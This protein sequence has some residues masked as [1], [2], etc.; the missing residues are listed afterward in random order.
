[1][2]PQCLRIPMEL[3]STNRRRLCERLR[4]RDDVPSAGAV[5]LLQ[6]GEQKQQ[7]CTDTD[8]VFRQ[9]HAHAHVAQIVDVIH[10]H[11]HVEKLSN[12]YSRRSFRKINIKHHP[13][14]LLQ[15]C[16][17]VFNWM[18]LHVDS[19]LH[20][21]TCTCVY[22]KRVQ[23]ALFF[24]FLWAGVL[25]PLAV[26]CDWG[27]LFCHG[28]HGHRACHSLHSSTAWWLCHLDGTVRDSFYKICSCRLT[29][30]LCLIV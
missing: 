26:W 5:V 19:K 7:Y 15:C 3:F 22:T 1:M 17:S 21:C 23:L 24:L 12:V 29:Y 13:P 30:Q 20:A 6:G 16:I 28:G 2:G 9:V 14:K 11:V 4:A 10:I 27:W 8:I 18:Q 25:L